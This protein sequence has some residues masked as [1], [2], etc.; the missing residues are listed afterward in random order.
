M[1]S[2]S[3]GTKKNW[4][5]ESILTCEAFRS[6]FFR[7]LIH[8][9]TNSIMSLC[10]GFSIKTGYCHQFVVYK[11]QDWHN[12]NIISWAIAFKKIRNDFYK[13]L[14]CVHF[15]VDS[16]HCLQ[17]LCFLLT[18]NYLLLYNNWRFLCLLNYTSDEVTNDLYKRSTSECISIFQEIF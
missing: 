4:K 18:K 3:L 11:K 9:Q 10:G 2:A 17:P 1:G 15:A 6:A 14:S 5:Q 7:S 12:K 8:S 13:I 16:Q